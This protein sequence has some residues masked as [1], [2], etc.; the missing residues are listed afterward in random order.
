MEKWTFLTN[1]A[2]VLL[3][4]AHDPEIRLRDVATRVGITERAA[5]RI[6]ADLEAEGYVTAERVGRR[7]RYAVHPEIPLRH[8]IEEHQAVGV[9]LRLLDGKQSAHRAARRSIGVVQAG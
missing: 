3:C 1:H 8:P 4:L 9:L 5:Q 7:N 2:H 6:L